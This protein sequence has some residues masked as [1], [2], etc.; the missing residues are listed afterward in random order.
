MREA[1]STMADI[2]ITEFMDDAAIRPLE[3]DYDVHWD[4]GLWQKP[5]EL[6]KLIA[7]AVALI[8]RNRTQVTADL[9]DQAP[10]LQVVGRLGVGLD[11]I[12]LDA[13]AARNVE[14]CPATGTNHVSVAEYVIGAMLILLRGAYLAGDR[15]LAG[16]WPRE[17]LIG[18]E[19]AGRTMA[20]L[21]YG[22]IGQA[23][24]DRARALGMRTI[25]HDTL[26]PASS[27]A[28]S[29]VER[30]DLDALLAEADVLSVHV[31]LTPETRLLLGPEE[32]AR[33]PEGALVI[34]TARGGIVDEDALA[35]GLRAGRL[36]GAAL[37][38]FETEPLTADAATRFVGV[39]N[40]L[41]TPHIGGVTQES[42]VRISTATVDN[43]RRVLK[44]RA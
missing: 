29:R 28:W 33:L 24:A 10:G 38:V 39:P 41:L 4:A 5:D 1:T 2:V 15:V 35:E 9:L 27:P 20:V 30:M 6:K 18:V 31:P 12:D 43:V 8:V 7:P 36:G 32:L 22:A 26:L 23:V 37:D 14:V 3:A 40:L 19:A 17:Q 16:E 11:N 44:E 25:A 34:N 13:C 42:Q 21:G